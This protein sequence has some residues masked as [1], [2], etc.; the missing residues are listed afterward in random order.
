MRVG[1][2][3]LSAEETR[4]LGCL[5][6]PFRTELVAKAEHADVI[7]SRGCANPAK[8]LIKIP[9]RLIGEGDYQDPISHGN[10]IV[11]LPFD[12]VEMVCQILGQVMNPRLALTYR[13]SCLAP[14]QYKAIPASLRNL[15][16]RT[17]E[18]DSNLSNHLRTEVAR[19]ILAKAFD[20]LGFALERKNPP[21]LVI[22][23]DVET[24][25]GLSRAC[26]LKT[27]EEDLGIQSIW[28]LPS[29]EYSIQK[30]IAKDLSE[31]SVIGSHDVRHDGRLIMIRK[32]EALVERL[33][34]SR[35]KLEYIFEKDV[36]SF[37]SP[38]LQFNREI[39][40]ALS[41]GGYSND[42]STTCWEP[43]HPLTMGGFGVECTSP[44]EMNGVVETPL[45]LFQDHQVLNVLQM[46]TKEA[47][48]L[49][50]HQ[51]RLVRAFAGDIVL[52]VHPDY[53]FSEDPREYRQL[54]IHLL[55]VDRGPLVS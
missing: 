26:S 47:A 20:G 34:E 53:S 3:G 8:P 25:Q 36:R 35:L 17:R 37:R 55:E 1:L 16:L 10:E 49:W 7:V 23:H 13:V 21:S 43:V 42:F 52:L 24:E 9:S 45:T 39:S 40:A 46:S 28:F 31:R 18:I 27:I 38:L 41:E 29:S 2:D 12:L 19:G 51:A 30:G 11:E 54:L 44:F 4:A 33:R 5:L 48:K 22:T 15:F 6:Y 50:I 14:F 32:H